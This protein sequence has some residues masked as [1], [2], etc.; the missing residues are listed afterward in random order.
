MSVIVQG[1]G[2]RT[3]I[4]NRRGL[5]GA[6]GAVGPAVPRTFTATSLGILPANS[7][8]VN[9]AAYDAWRDNSSAAYNSSILVFDVASTY[10][11][12]RRLGVPG[13]RTIRGHSRDFTK[14]KYTG[15]GLRGEETSFVYPVTSSI[16]I[17]NIQL[18][19]RDGV[20]LNGLI[21]Y[22]IEAH[23]TL[24]PNVAGPTIRAV[25][26]YA[27]F[28]DVAGFRGLNNSW[29]I[30]DCLAYGGDYSVWLESCSESRILRCLFSEWRTACIWNR[31]SFTIG[32]GFLNGGKLT[33]AELVAGAAAAPPYGLDIEGT[34]NCVVTGATVEGA[35]TAA[36][37]IRGK[38]SN[39]HMTKTR[40]NNG[41]HAL[42]DDCNNSTVQGACTVAQVGAK[43]INN[44]RNC[45]AGLAAETNA[46]HF[47][48]A[49]KFGV[50]EWQGY[51][52]H[53]GG[54]LFSVANTKPTDGYWEKGDEVFPI[55]S[56]SGFPRSWVCTVNGQPNAMTGNPNLTFAEVGASGDTITRD[57]G[58]WIAD[59]FL[60]GAGIYVSGTV[61]NNLV[62]AS[63]ATIVTLSATVITLGVTDLTPEGPLNGVTL[64]GTGVF[65]STGNIP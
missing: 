18:D 42:F 22:T 59:G 21:D 11:F 14:L 41:V 1:P 64:T 65:L 53:I 25:G 40:S 43:F 55:T 7:A 61:S 62:L 39:V 36:F 19:T 60:E 26:V 5:T 13:N 10:N 33:V 17:E 35:A 32:A 20:T 37:R 44:A 47:D 23:G 9:G 12:D 27:L 30:E 2:Q 15:A 51:R 38:S 52:R 16:F 29:V 54:K 34:A 49:Q 63:G 56:A 4:V 50:L 31:G 46:G 58:S 6:A 28:P 24:S 8:A 45:Q 57:A 48:V 3:L